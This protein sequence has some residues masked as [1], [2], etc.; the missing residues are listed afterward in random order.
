MAN[1][2]TNGFFRAELSAAFAALTA[3]FAKIG[4]EGIDSDPATLM[5]TVVIPVVLAAFVVAA[6]KWVNP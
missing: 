5:R 3:I 2:A 1:T 4:L 6:G